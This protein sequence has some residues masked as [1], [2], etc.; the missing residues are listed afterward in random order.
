MREYNILTS[1][2]R[3]WFYSKR[4][5]TIWRYLQSIAWINCHISN[6]RIVNE[7]WFFFQIV[8]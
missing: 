4:Y 6:K 8:S 3:I 2:I 5:T 1:K 7:L